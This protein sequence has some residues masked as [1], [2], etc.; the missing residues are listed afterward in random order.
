MGSQFTSIE[1]TD[2]LTKNNIKIS[3]DGRNRWRDNIFIERLWKTVKY[4]GVYLKAYQSINRA[5]REL[6]R[7]LAGYDTRR[8]H[9]ALNG[10]I[11][12]EVYC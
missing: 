3:M 10:R 8:P 7:F 9:Q 4:E 1:F 12:D 6:A 2:I 11:P 5:K